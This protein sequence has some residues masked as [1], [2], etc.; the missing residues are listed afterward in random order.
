MESCPRI[1]ETA[2]PGKEVNAEIDQMPI[3]VIRGMVPRPVL[4]FIYTYIFIEFEIVQEKTIRAMESS[5]KEERI[6]D[7]LA[8]AVD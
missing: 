6:N 4:I 3:N 1:G 8:V 2:S 7:N 5:K